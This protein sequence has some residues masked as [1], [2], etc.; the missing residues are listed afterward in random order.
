MIRHLQY[1]LQ[2]GFSSFIDDAEHLY[3]IDSDDYE[4]SVNNNRILT[5]VF[6]KAK[7]KYYSHWGVRNTMCDP[8]DKNQKEGLKANEDLETYYPNYKENAQSIKDDTDNGIN[9]FIQ[10]GGRIRDLLYRMNSIDP[11][12]REYMNRG[13]T[14]TALNE[15]FNNFD[16][17]FRSSGRDDMVTVG[18]MGHE[19]E[20]ILLYL[21]NGSRIAI[22]I[23]YKVHVLLNYIIRITNLC[24]ILQSETNQITLAQNDLYVPSYKYFLIQSLYD[25]SCQNRIDLSSPISKDNI[26][27][28]IKSNNDS[29]VGEAQISIDDRLYKISLANIILISFIKNELFEDETIHNLTRLPVFN[30]CIFIDYTN[31]KVLKD[32]FGQMYISESFRKVMHTTSIILHQLL[33]F[34]FMDYIKKL[35]DDKLSV[36][37]PFDK[38]L[39]EDREFQLLWLSIEERYSSKEL[40][41]I[42]KE[43]M[44]EVIAL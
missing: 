40:F 11:I 5:G 7:C 19:I 41:E 22:N 23:N 17:S 6:D 43:Y 21:L 32:D 31:S 1:Y 34:N 26:K 12:E 33:L 42:F 13:N 37:N 39:F 38:V 27:E 24:K 9:N 4:W 2:D 15:N 10:N 35:T 16:T 8:L 44:K 25:S 36:S 28:L 3:H 20:A 18:I 14:L 29:T 30:P